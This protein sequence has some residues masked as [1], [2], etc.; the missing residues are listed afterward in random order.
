VHLSFASA[1]TFVP[2]SMMWESTVERQMCNLAL[3]GCVIWS[4]VTHTD[5]VSTVTMK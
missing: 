4:G 5:K 1:L 2:D 3:H